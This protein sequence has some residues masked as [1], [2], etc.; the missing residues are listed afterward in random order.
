VAGVI[1]FV[2]RIAGL[3]EPSLES[4]L[5][6][7]FSWLSRFLDGLIVVSSMVDAAPQGFKVHR[8]WA[9]EAPKVG[10][11]VKT[12]SYCYAVLKN[13]GLVDT[14]YVRTFSP[15]E[16][17]AL[18]FGKKFLRKRAVF[19]LP[20]TWLLE[21]RGLKAGL[22]RWVLS[23]AVY[24][25]DLVILYTP[26]M[27][28]SVKAFLPKIME[29]KVKYL[30]NAVN[31]ERFKPGEPDEKVLA[32]YLTPRPKRLLLYVGMIARRKGILDLMRAFARI[33]EKE[34]KTVL[35]LAGREEEPYAGKVK[36]LVKK[37]RLE[38]TVKFLGPVPNEGV[39]HLMRA[40]DLFVHASRGGEGIPRAVL[41]AMAC[42]RPVVATKVGGVREAVRDGET[43]YTVEVGDIDGFAE[44]A[45][46]LLRDE[47]LRRRLGRNARLVV[48]EEFNYE[49]V[50]PKLAKLIASCHQARGRVHA[51]HPLRR[52]ST[53]A[54][55]M[56]PAAKCSQPLRH[57][58]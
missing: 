2:R 29:D 32:K 45:L 11:L 4:E 38:N 31:V 39:V 8:A 58:N 9:V 28:P 7:E 40:C 41:E 37:L 47:K 24:A 5:F 15:P 46:R 18:W 17:V 27:L 43:G 12:I 3:S 26:L 14:V 19:L 30:H 56:P 55:H 35:A 16:A 6:E 51:T 53:P 25:A 36:A 21:R 42:G 50:I 1:T 23:R 57:G 48:E 54:P 34:P 52:P 22:Y 33:A 49:K 13:A 10:W 44:A 20:G